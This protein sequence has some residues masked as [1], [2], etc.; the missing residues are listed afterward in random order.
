MPT[1]RGESLSGIETE[2]PADLLGK[3]SVLILGYVQDAQFDADRWLFGLLQAETPVKIMEVPT[4]RGLVPSLIDFRIDSGMRSGIP[5]E[6]WSSVV[7]VYGDPAMKLLSFTGN[8][9]PRNVRVLLLDG[10][11]VVIWMHDRGFSAGKMLELDGLAREAVASLG[12]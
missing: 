5:N 6:D 3:V 9:T 11:G 2:L 10:N 7:T 12:D 8:E 4:I 1:V